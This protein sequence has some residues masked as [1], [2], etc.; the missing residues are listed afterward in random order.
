MVKIRE[1]AVTFGPGQT[2]VGIETRAVDAEAGAN[3]APGRPAVILLN[4][5]VVHRVGPH[6]LTVNLAR[7][8]GRAGHLAFRF[9]LA[10]LGDSR[11]RKG[12]ASYETRVIED[13]RAAMDHLQKANKIDRFILGGLCS[14]ADNSIRVALADER[15]A[16]IMLLDPYAYRTPGFY[17]RHY[18]ARIG[19]LQSWLGASRRA[20]TALVKATRQRIAHRMNGA[21]GTASATN[22]AQPA[23]TPQYKRYHPPREQFAAQLRQLIDRGTAI[24]IAYSGSLDAVYNY[25]DQFDDAFRPYGI[26]TEDIRITFAPLVN[27]TYTELRAQRGLA[28]ALVGWAAALPAASGAANVAKS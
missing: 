13:V 25:A 15:V 12:T 23:R 26:G 21:D 24:Y 1:R 22:G 5:G 16:A 28:E 17:L 4:A 9:D 14:G 18:M 3:G 10:G 7:R 19:R 6:R 8:F 20:A 2:L 11:A 27:H